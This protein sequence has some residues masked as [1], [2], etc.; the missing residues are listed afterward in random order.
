MCWKGGVGRGVSTCDNEVGEGGVGSAFG[1][2]LG[3]WGGRVCT[4][5]VQVV[6]AEDVCPV[7]EQQVEE[8]R[9]ADGRRHVQRRLTLWYQTTPHT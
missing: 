3:M 2:G 1:N 4:Y 9:V 5:L 8:P 6:D 7:G